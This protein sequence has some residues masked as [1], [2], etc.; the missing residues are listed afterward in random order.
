VKILEITPKPWKNGVFNW[1]TRNRRPYLTDDLPRS[2]VEKEIKLKVIVYKTNTPGYEL[3]SFIYIPPNAQDF[4]K[5]VNLNSYIRVEDV[6][7]RLGTGCQLVYNEDKR[8]HGLHR[9]PFCAWAQN[10]H[11]IPLG[12]GP[13]EDY[14]R[15]ILLGQANAYATNERMFSKWFSKL[16]YAQ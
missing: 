1:T 3:D 13:L 8:L 12:N 10:G 4:V 5:A 2:T 9:L 11:S 6:I 14:H 16:F 7:N 15:G